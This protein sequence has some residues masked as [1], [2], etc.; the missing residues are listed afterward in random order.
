VSLIYGR[1]SVSGERSYGVDS[2]QNGNYIPCTGV[3]SPLNTKPKSQDGSDEVKAGT[4]IQDYEVNECKLARSGAGFCHV[5]STDDDAAQ[6]G[7]KIRE[8]YENMS[9]GDDVHAAS[10]TEWASIRQTPHRP[11]G[12][13]S[14]QATEGRWTYATEDDSYDTPQG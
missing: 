12:D 2:G 8:K 1:P 6:V 11:L 7:C 14:S 5:P 3:Y 9:P 4:N 13:S 10:A